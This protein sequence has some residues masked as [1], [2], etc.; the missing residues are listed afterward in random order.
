M[1]V[2]R[3]SENLMPGVAIPDSS[4]ES[5]LIL[6]SRRFDFVDCKPQLSSFRESALTG[7][8]CQPKMLE[9]KFFYDE[10]G[11]LLFERICEVPEYY[12]VIPPFL[13]RAE[14]RGYAAMASFCLGVIPP[15]AMLGRS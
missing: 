6:H 3:Q 9:P 12:P 7:L 11:S 1:F 8:A 4:N 5:R 13:K 2:G 10:E 14:S 15:M